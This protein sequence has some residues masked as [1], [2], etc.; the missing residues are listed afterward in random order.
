MQDRIF[1]VLTKHFLKLPV[2][3]VFNRILDLHYKNKSCEQF[4][5]VI[6]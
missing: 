3:M 6:S 4:G 2:Y 5:T 1:T